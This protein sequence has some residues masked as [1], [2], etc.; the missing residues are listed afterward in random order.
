M[1]TTSQIKLIRALP[2]HAAKWLA[3]RSAVAAKGVV[4]LDALA[5]PA[6]SALIEA[7]GLDLAARDAETYRFVILRDRRA[8][9]VMSVEEVNWAQ[10][11]AA[12]RC[13]AV[14]DDAESW[15]TALKQLVTA[16]ID[17]GLSRFTSRIA[18]LD[19]RGVQLFEAVGF[20]KEGLLRQHGYAGGQRIDELL[21]GLL[22]PEFVGLETGD[23]EPGIISGYAA[24][25]R[26]FAEAPREIAAN[27]RAEETGEII[28][29]IVHLPKLAVDADA[30]IVADFGHG[31]MTDDWKG[32]SVIVEYDIGGRLLSFR[33][34]ITQASAYACRLRAP[35][36]IRPWGAVG[37][38][39]VAG[40]FEPVDGAE[41]CLRPTPSEPV[42]GVLIK[43]G[44]LHAQIK[45]SGV[46]CKGRQRILEFFE[47]VERGGAPLAVSCEAG[48]LWRASC[49]RD[50]AR[51]QDGCID[52]AGQ[53]PQGTIEGQQLWVTG[54]IEGCMTTIGVSVASVGESGCRVKPT[55]ESYRHQRRK[56]PRFVVTRQDVLFLVAGAGRIERLCD[57]STGGL[58]CLVKAELSLRLGDEVKLEIEVAAK[59]S[60]KLP[61]RCV[62]RR[63]AA[64]VPGQDR[65]GF[66]FINVGAFQR[67]LIERLVS[68]LAGPLV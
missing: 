53:V 26:S 17:A 55:G 23:A 6:L 21:F 35:G 39:G 44:A 29:G 2:T 61:A 10:G 14:D 24:I 49:S 57:V 59:R 66:N 50:P 9:G 36:E 58:G 41:L 37:A 12:L 54:L 8:V 16:L 48:R 3:W 4:C 65:I 30:I 67:R 63:P 22:S 31:T 33:S 43:G 46:I 13:V 40:P 18:A 20:R 15:Q 56:H 1:S 68:R 32:R 38:R 52:L 47:S 5:E 64:D 60:V 7:G 11:R 42:F 19:E 28:Q 34:S 25:T 51:V 27:I 45:R 62:F